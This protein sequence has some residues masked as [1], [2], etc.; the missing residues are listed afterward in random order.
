MV[1]VR[2]PLGEFIDAQEGYSKGLQSYIRYIVTIAAGMVAAL[3]SLKSGKDETQLQHLVF[4]SSI[5]L[6]VL[7]I[8]S[9]SYLLFAEVRLLLKNREAHRMRLEELSKGNSFPAVLELFYPW[10]RKYFSKIFLPSL[11]LSLIGLSIYAFLRY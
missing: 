4:A 11:M 2:S 9:G 6:L 5:A 7:G 8:L 3:T 1:T 10:P